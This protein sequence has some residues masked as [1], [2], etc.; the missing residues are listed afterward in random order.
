MLERAER[1]PW[2]EGVAVPV[3][4][5]EDLIGLK[6]QALVNDPSRQNRDE[7]DILQILRHAGEC[8]IAIDWELITDYLTLFDLG[9]Q[10]EDLIQAYGK[11]H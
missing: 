2:P 1:L 10:L 11:T 9:H 4:H 8:A 7:A 6:I 5:F 3:V